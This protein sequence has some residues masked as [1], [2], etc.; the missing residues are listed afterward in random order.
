MKT[1]YRTS[2]IIIT[3]LLLTSCYT[4][5]RVRVD[6]FDKKAMLESEEYLL[7]KVENE[8]R[9][10]EILLSSSFQQNLKKYYSNQVKAQLNFLKDR[11]A[12]P[13]TIERIMST[14]DN[15]LTLSFN[16]ANSQYR[17]ALDNY[18]KFKTNIENFDAT[19]AKLDKLAGDQ[20]KQEYTDELQNNLIALD[21]VPIEV[22]NDAFEAL[23]AD[24]DR[25]ANQTLAT[26][27]TSIGSDPFASLITKSPEKYWK[28]YKSTV[29]LSEVGK[30]PERSKKRSRY[31][32][33]VV[34]TLF[35]NADIAIKMESPGN[36]VIKG[37]RLDAS[38]SLKASFKVLNQGIKYAAMAGGI[39]V[40]GA[41]GSKGA[42]SSENATLNTLEYAENPTLQNKIDKH[43]EITE[44]ATKTF[45]SQ[46]FTQNLVLE[47]V[48]SSASEKQQALDI[49]NKAYNIYKTEL[50][51][52][53]TEK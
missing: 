31:N 5:M 43:K 12:D 51:H 34:K 17:L 13:Q 41:G 35:G 36:F 42:E 3:S 23:N 28:K 38:E 53:N 26:Y 24:L 40:P 29:G 37:V 14:V 39:P 15:K 2:L 48:N 52:L 21:L 30:K 46:V 8:V 25:Y 19:Q 4:S 7:V 32:L 20:K 45:L 33:N 9:E 6:T 18:T 50:Q 27:G 22:I 1:N 16:D 44:S 10:L 47:D 49:I 11:D